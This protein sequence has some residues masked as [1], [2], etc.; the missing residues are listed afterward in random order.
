MDD[1]LTKGSL[2]QLGAA[3]RERS[4]LIPELVQWYL[5]QIEANNHEGLAVN[6]IRSI[7]PRVHEHAQRLANEIANGIDRGPLHGIPIVVKDNIQVA[8][9]PSGAAGC[10]ALE[11]RVPTTS[12]T[13]ITRLQRA[14]AIILGSANMTEF[15]DY[16]SDTMPAEFSSLGG[17]VRNPH[18]LRY[19]RGQG[20]SVGS[21]A[22]V[23]ALM[24]PAAIG[25][26]TQNSIQ[27]PASYSS[28]VGFKP[29]VG[30]VSCAGV[31]PLVPSQDSPGP[32]TR[33]VDD[34]AL[35]FLALR[36]PDP[37]DTATLN[38]Q[39]YSH[40]GPLPERL[41]QV[42]IGVPR[43]AMAER[44]EYADVK[45]Q[46]D[47]VLRELAKAGATIV[48]PCD[49]PSAEQLLQQRS[50]VFRTEFKAA[51]N[52]LLAQ[53]N[54]GGDIRSLADLVRWN[55]AHPEHMPYG[56]SLLLAAEAT[57]GLDSADYIADRLR[58]IEL[59]RNSG[60]EAARRATGVDVLIAPMDSAARCTGKCGA[61]ALTIPA[62]LAAKGIPFGVTLFTSIGEDLKLL[63][64][65][66]L[67]ERAIGQSIAAKIS[68]SRNSAR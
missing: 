51:L 47:G 16:V 34:A 33:T 56:Q 57:D 29:S 65:G 63:A 43:L 39:L 45:S 21:A 5:A 6:C 13:L 55:E 37:A 26:E 36:G 60:I 52:A 20:S 9:R 3:I 18:G 31:V 7:D 48:D 35:L 54:A 41:T 62:G 40:R 4:V 42:R 27:A 15:A 23:A 46:F 12:A 32:L 68:P 58:D 19:G 17:V 2:R 1:V 14:G 11:Q 50:C 8:G 66:T 53:E 30:S 10:K 28:V 64:I 38:T 49:L 22:S 67:V 25:S 59:S 24:S 61:P 44:K